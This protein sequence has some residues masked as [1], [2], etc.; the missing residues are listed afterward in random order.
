MRQI[1]TTQE[2]NHCNRDKNNLLLTSSGQVPKGVNSERHPRIY[3]LQERA[4]W[5][6]VA[7]SEQAGRADMT[8]E[9]EYLYTPPDKNCEDMFSQF[10]FLQEFL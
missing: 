5:P 1:I 7:V 2:K 10:D 9:A 4:E 8:E 3:M 6:H